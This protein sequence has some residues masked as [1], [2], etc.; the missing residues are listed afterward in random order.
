MI[1]S[2]PKKKRNKDIKKSDLKP[3]LYFLAPGKLDPHF[4]YL[5]RKLS[6]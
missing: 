2:K 6:N 1:K 5:L 3:Q 4:R